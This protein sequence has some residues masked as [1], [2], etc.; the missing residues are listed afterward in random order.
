M[1]AGD[2]R[3]LLVHPDPAKPD[4]SGGQDVGV[5]GRASTPSD[6]GVRSAGSRQSPC[7]LQCRGSIELRGE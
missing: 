3:A 4:S 6:G 2:R 5:P 1:R 7:L